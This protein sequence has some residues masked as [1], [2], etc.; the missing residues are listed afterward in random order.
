MTT[1][2]RFT[3]TLGLWSVVMFGLAYMAPMIVLGT[4]GPLA[5]ASRGTAAMAYS[6]GALGI[7]LTA[8]S[9]GVMARVF[10]V[11]GSAYS[12]ARHSLNSHLGFLVG[13]AMLLDYFF[14]PMVIW[15]IG[16]SFLA[17]ALPGWPIWLWITVFVIVTSLINIIGIVFASRINFLLMV[18]QLAVLLAFIFLAGRYVVAAAGP[19]GLLSLKPFFGEGVPITASVAGAALAAYAFLG[20]DAVSTLTEETIDAKRTMPKAVMIVALFG[21][22]IFIV[23]AYLTQ[24]AHPGFAFSDV[25][26]AAFEIARMIG[27]DLFATIFLATLVMTQFTA[28]IAAQASVGRFLFAMGRDG[29]LPTGLFGKL[30]P[31]W[32][33]PI[34]N[35][36]LVGLAGFIGISLDVTTSTSFINFGAFMAFTAVNLSVISLYR[37]RHAELSGF[38]AWRGII[39]PASGALFDFVMLFNLDRNAQ[40]LGLI[41]LALGVFYL[42]F[43]TGGFRKPPPEVRF[44]HDLALLQ[45]G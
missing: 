44:E 28:G 38:G 11:A 21:A 7:T 19:G 34:A 15:L 8:I 1:G 3:K 43:L 5:D 17:T 36:L 14:I 26:T 29:V 37:R 39:L 13:W 24:L 33:T 42:A 32:K 23:S 35:L 6:L 45:E 20:F 16:A 10:P 41:W 4:F 12:Y 31:R 22:V 27:S 30:H 9:Y 2:T 18:L 40:I 25:D